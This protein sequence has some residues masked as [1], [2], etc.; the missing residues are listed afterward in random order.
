MSSITNPK[1]PANRIRIIR[2]MAHQ[3]QEDV[4]YL[5]GV[6]ATTLS[7]WENWNQMPS[8]Y[9]SIGLSVVFNRLVDVIFSDYRDEWLKII[10]ERRKKLEARKVEK[11]ND[12]DKR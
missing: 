10:G 11:A 12:N 7:K 8:L 9:H 5:L 4:A 6:P 2:M 1:R 3:T